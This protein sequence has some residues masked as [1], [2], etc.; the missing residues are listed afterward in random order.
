MAWDL[1][2]ARRAAH[3]SAPHRLH[4][5]EEPLPACD[6]EAYAALGA[7]ASVRI[8]AGEMAGSAAE[9]ERLVR[10]RPV[11][12]LQVDVS[13]VGLT[14]GVQVAALAAEHGIPCVNHT[15]SYL[16]NAAASA[17]FAAAIE[18]TDL[19]ECQA[20]PNEIRDAL[21]QG[22]LR[23]EAGWVRVPTGPGLG[24]EVNETVLRQFRSTEP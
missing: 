9:L 22:Q 2:S 13:R 15:Y 5:L 20:T 23:P 12:V 18:R 4:W 14:E 1:A 21:D 10:A 7:D 19:F 17:Q 24:V 11:D 16:L 3:R 6:V 8:A